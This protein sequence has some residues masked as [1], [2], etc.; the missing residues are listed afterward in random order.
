MSDPLIHRIRRDHGKHVSLL[1]HSGRDFV[2]C[3]Q[4]GV[5]VEHYEKDQVIFDRATRS[6]RSAIT[7][8]AAAP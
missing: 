3:S 6:A 4:Q 2:R 7:P 5:R 1:R 8:N